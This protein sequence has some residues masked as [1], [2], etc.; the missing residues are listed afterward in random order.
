MQ[1]LPGFADQGGINGER[2]RSDS[3]GTQAIIPDY[4]F[5]CY[6]NVTQWGAY[7]ERSFNRYTL[8]FQVWRRSGGGQ[9]TTG[10][11]DFVGNNRFS[12]ISPAQRS[13]GQIL[14][15]VPVE[16][17]IQV[18]PGDVIGLYLRGEDS[19][20][21]GVELHTN[22]PDVTVWF[23]PTTAA[24]PTRIKVGNTNSIGLHSSTTAA[25]VI[26]AMVLPST[27]SPSPTPSP[28]SQTLALVQFSAPS[29]PQ[30][31]SFL[32]SP[33]T[34]SPPVGSG[35]PVGAIVAIVIVVI[36]LGV[37]ILVF[38]LALALR[39]RSKKMVDS[40][41]N[42]EYSGKLEIMHWNECLR[43]CLSEV[44]NHLATSLFMTSNV[45]KTSYSCY[46]LLVSVYVT[47][48]EKRMDFH[49]QYNK[50]YMVLLY[51]DWTI[52]KCSLGHGQYLAADGVHSAADRG[53]GG[54]A[55][56]AVFPGH[57]V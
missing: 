14:R 29:I 12:S 22:S 45:L 37:L 44:F 10:N 5:D 52:P 1:N 19:N 21:D 11:Y 31:S 41:D 4:S 9:G 30:S 53:G 25:P 27:T 50:I 7:V 16:Q 8:D 39:R 57:P 32:P 54:G 6:G 28:T 23:T 40:L 55:T 2:L 33:D 35:L 34:T 18:R 13:G 26:T 24:V 51:N 47:D 42:F 49:L 43:V 48:S 17:Q 46:Y 3:Q 15:D 56:V 38:I 20:D 36:V